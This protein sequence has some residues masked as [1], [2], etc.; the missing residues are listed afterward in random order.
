MACPKTIERPVREQLRDYAEVVNFDPDEQ[1][2]WRVTGGLVR[3]RF[4]FCFLC[5]FEGREQDGRKGTEW[6]DRRVLG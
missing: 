4:R 1:Q 2:R 6:N 3:E 5:C